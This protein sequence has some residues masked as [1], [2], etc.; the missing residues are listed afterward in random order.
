[1]AIAMQAANVTDTIVVRIKGMRCEE[2]AHKVN[3]VLRKLNGVKSIDYN[4]ERRTAT[5]AYDQQLTCRDTIEAR[6]AA[7]GRYK[8]SNYSK[9]NVIRR[10][11]GLRMD[12]MHCQ[13]CADRIKTWSDEDTKTMKQTNRR[14][15]KFIN[16]T[17][18]VGFQR[19][20]KTAEGYYNVA[21][22]TDGNRLIVTITDAIGARIFAA[23][24]AASWDDLEFIPWHGSTPEQAAANVQGI[25]ILSDSNGTIY[26]LLGRRVVKP[27]K[28][29]YVKDGK[30]IIIK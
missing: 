11:M 25:T 28:G 6:L 15:Y 30:K 26:D 4:L 24:G 1:M 23:N 12:D 13:K 17:G 9:D 5:I 16:A 27:L 18:K 3:T 2:C 14:Y 20:P 7:T 21:D 8:A 22:C 29:I 10:G 19:V